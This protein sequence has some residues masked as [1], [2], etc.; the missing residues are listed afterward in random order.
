LL[1]DLP[2]V[3]AFFTTSS[4][5]PHP[6]LVAKYYY[7][8]TIVKEG[9]D[10]NPALLDYMHE[11]F[12]EQADRMGIHAIALERGAQCDHLHLQ[13]LMCTD[14]ADGTTA[15]AWIKRKL[16]DSG[17][18]VGNL[19]EYSIRV[20]SLTGQNL[21][22]PI[23]ILG[24][25]Q[26]DR[27]KPHFQCRLS[28]NITPDAQ[29]RAHVAW[30]TYGNLHSKDKSV[31][32]PGNLF[33]YC[34]KFAYLHAMEPGTPIQSVLIDM[35]RTGSFLPSPLFLKP[36]DPLHRYESIWRLT[37]E[38]G[39]PLLDDVANVFFNGG[40]VGMWTSEDARGR[41]APMD[42]LS[43]E[44]SAQRAAHA[45]HAT[46]DLLAS[47]PA[48]L[49]A[50]AQG[51][52]MADVRSELVA[53]VRAA[54]LKRVRDDEETLASSSGLL[55]RFAPGET[56]ELEFHIGH[57]GSGKTQTVMK[58]Y[59]DAFLVTYDCGGSGVYFDGYNGEEVII[60]D[61]CEDIAQHIPFRAALKLFDTAPCKWQVKH[62]A[63]VIVMAKKVVFTSVCPP[64]ELFD[65]PRGEWRRRIRD[66]GHI[67]HHPLPEH[68][69][70]EEHVP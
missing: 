27:A 48:D 70:D 28:A 58:A 25:V 65:D 6:A 47:V 16:R 31:I 2:L 57:T 34:D 51:A 56:L 52:V 17:M 59:P 5:T 44:A 50:R 42:L 23:G 62:Q 63:P 61:D 1:A 13:G 8:V 9:A 15:N 24:Y 11:A 19:N 29:R 45:L 4:S 35:L 39:V 18:L 64:W 22:T 3:V 30:L 7:S 37:M 46:Q 41:V 54:N 36:N 10:I 55:P 21:H 38:R 32:T 33:D 67:V 49:A 68:A 60:I 66:Y 40:E 26:K 43:A 53:R 69:P 14:M 12:E 20:A